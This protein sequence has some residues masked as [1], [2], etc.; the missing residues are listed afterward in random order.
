MSHPGRPLL[1]ARLSDEASKDGGSPGS[2]RQ[3]GGRPKR[4]LIESACSACRRRKS[5]CDGLRPSCSRC[6][7]L[8]TDC[9]YEAEEGESRWSAL[10][11]RN[12]VLEAERDQVREL[13]AFVQTRPEPEAMDIFQ[14]MRQTH[15]DDV[16]ILLRQIKENTM[17]MPPG[18]GPLPPQGTAAERLPPIQTILDVPGRGMTPVH[19]HLTHSHSLSSED[20]RGSSVPD[21]IGGM[22]QHR[23]HLEPL[24]PS[25]LAQHQQ[26][27]QHQGHQHQQQHHMMPGPISYSSEESSNSIGSTSMDAPRPYHTP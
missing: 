6:Q 2:G 12:Q 21:L 5:R 25:L 10:R 3:P 1:A 11:R 23:P 16:L 8:R 22:P 9:Q 20:S 13:L 7:N 14:R 27:Q 26:H 24:E 15:Y 4:T 17:G 18:M 19:P